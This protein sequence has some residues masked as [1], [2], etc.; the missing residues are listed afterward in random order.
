[1]D[2]AIADDVMDLVFKNNQEYPVYI[3]AIVGGG[4]LTFNIY[5]KETRDPNRTVTYVSETLSSEQATGTIMLHQ[6]TQ[7]DI[8]IM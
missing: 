2:A 4:S 5:G 3:E 1:M 8:S 6:M 7:S